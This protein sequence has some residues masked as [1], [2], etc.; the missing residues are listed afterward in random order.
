MLPCLSSPEIARVITPGSV[1][2]MKG[3]G[4]RKN[5]SVS[6]RSKI[7]ERAE[8]F[9]FSAAKICDLVGKKKDKT[10]PPSKNSR[11]QSL[12]ETGS[13]NSCCERQGFVLTLV[14]LSLPGFSTPAG[15]SGVP[16][17]THAR[18]TNREGDAF[19]KMGSYYVSLSPR[20]T[21]G[22]KWQR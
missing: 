13:E 22:P 10:Q 2:T 17:V 20:R 21:A 9:T 4:A 12:R 8:P 18:P 16:P 5:E 3:S 11:L 14:A 15:T 1:I 6:T 7:V 19:A